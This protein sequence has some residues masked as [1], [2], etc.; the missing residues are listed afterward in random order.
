MAVASLI[1][2]I[3]S[4]L[5]SIMP[6]FGIIAIV[7]AI[8]SFVL[9][10]VAVCKKNIQNK[11]K[12]MQITGVVLSSI[13]FAISIFWIFCIILIEI[14]NTS[15][16]NFDGNWDASI[17]Q[18]RYIPIYNLNE[19]ADLGD[20]AIK[21]E[22]ITL[23][24]NENTIKSKEGYKYVSYK[25]HIKNISC[26][27]FNLY[28]PLL[29][30]LCDDGDEYITDYNKVYSNTTLI[31]RIINPGEITTGIIAFEIPDNVD[32]EYIFFTLFDEVYK[33]KVN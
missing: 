6:G 10:L 3:L 31:K 27:K 14:I 32:A 24:D 7:P 20:I 17:E 33:F 18:N 25:V 2:G 29:Y 5:T 21:I 30:I 12:A 11:S 9:G 22:S 1:L 26:Y 4:L 19:D 28:E 15:F 16:D 8:I 23:D 13:A